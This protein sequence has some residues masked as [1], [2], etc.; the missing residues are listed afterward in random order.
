MWT[1]AE[2]PRRLRVCSQVMS[3]IHV[4]ERGQ[5]SLRYRE[6]SSHWTMAV[7]VLTYYCL[8]F[9]SLWRLFSFIPRPAYCSGRPAKCHGQPENVQEFLKLSDFS[10]SSRLWKPHPVEAQDQRFL[11]P[12]WLVPPQPSCPPVTIPG[13]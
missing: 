12:S 8:L 9:L 3:E 1:W 10:V 5:H 13:L 6:K 4:G 7:S 2:G 11:F